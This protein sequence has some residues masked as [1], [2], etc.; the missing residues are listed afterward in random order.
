M[1]IEPTLLAIVGPTASG[2]SCLAIHLA[3]RFNGEIVNCDS[4]QMYRGFDIGTGKTPEAERQ[5]IP[6]HLIDVLG[7]EEKFA[8]GEYARVAKDIISAITSRG[9]VPVVVGGTGFYLRALIHGL[10]PGPTRNPNLRERLQAREEQKGRGYLHRIL[11]R[12]DPVAA[13]TMHPNDTPKVIRAIEVCLQARRPISE[14]FQLGRQALRGYRVCKLGLNPPRE[15]LYRTINE[16]TR[17]MFEHGITEEVQQHLERGLP[18]TAPPLASLGYR[19]ALLYLQ[20]SISLEEAVTTAQAKTRQYAKRQ[21]TWFRK[22]SDV[23]WL[24]GFG[25]D[26]RIQDQAAQIVSALLT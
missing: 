4:L 1:T 3:Q 26:S 10:F 12:I 22:E 11:T 7:P 21:L 9:K 25:N 16:R 23:T 24:A 8:A 14:M 20:G 15:E 17:W 19:E 2:K 6:H 5:G 18:K 13:A